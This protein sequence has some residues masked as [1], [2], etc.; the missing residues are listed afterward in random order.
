[1]ATQNIKQLSADYKKILNRVD[2]AILIILQLNEDFLYLSETMPVKL[3][4]RLIKKLE[5]IKGNINQIRYDLSILE[6]LQ[7]QRQNHG[8]N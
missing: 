8:Q 5:I 1:M 2:H 6:E 7:Q 3:A 4:N